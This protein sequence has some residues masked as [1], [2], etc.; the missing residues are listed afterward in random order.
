MSCVCDTA[1]YDFVTVYVEDS[2]GIPVVSER[3]S[4]EDDDDMYMTSASFNLSGT[5]DVAE[6]LW[7][8]SAFDG[9]VTGNGTT[10]VILDKNATVTDW[11]GYLRMVMFVNTFNNATAGVREVGVQLTDLTH[12]QQRS[13]IATAY[14]SMQPVNDAPELLNVPITFTYVEDAPP[15]AFLRN[16]TIRDWDD[17]SLTQLVVTLNNIQDLSFVTLVEVLEVDRNLTEHDLGLFV[18]YVSG[19][20]L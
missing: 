14:I 11:L 5:S 15:I 19:M 13:N 9:V 20:K 4:I 2:A 7:I 18:D 12:P 1:D 10:T 16:T 8:S 3:V 17:G 6:Y